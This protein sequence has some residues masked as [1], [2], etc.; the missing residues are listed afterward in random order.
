M[1]DIRVRFAPSPTGYLHVGGLRTAL[2]N[3]LFAK[4]NNGKIILRIEDTDQSRI[5]KGAT[6]GLIDIF[7]KF[8][9]NFDEGPNSKNNG[10]SYFQSN[11]LDI[12]NEHAKYL[13]EKGYAYKCH[14]SKQELVNLREEASDLKKDTQFL[15]EQIRSFSKKN[16]SESNYVIRFKTPSDQ[17]VE[18]NDIVR[19]VVKFNSNEIDDQILIKADGFPTYHM[20]NVVDDFN[21]KISHVI[22]GEEWLSSTPKHI[23]LY[24]AFGY[25]IP[26]FAH[27]PL[28]LNKDKSKLSKRQGDVSVED[29]LQKGYTPE[30]LINFVSLLGWHPENNEE[31]LS[32][33]KLID[34]FSINRVQKGGATFDIEKLNWINSNYIKNMPMDDFIS[35]AMK[36]LPDDLKS[37]N[38]KNKSFLIFMKDRVKTFNDLIDEAKWFYYLPKYIDDDIKILHLDINQQMLSYLRKEIVIVDNISEGFI[39][40]LMKKIETKFNIKG[41][42]LFFP[43]RLSI[44]GKTH[45]PNI[46]DIC[47]ILGKKQVLIRL[48][49]V[50]IKQC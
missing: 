13:L 20:A 48:N 10:S 8:D 32:L 38:T 28:L 39:L 12:Y 31:I 42:D 19:G 2:Y 47:N 1:K 35:T 30:A 34:I 15:R 17:L 23:L 21:M 36:F 46:Y 41:K 44:Y 24:K 27:L 4:Q 33:N 22:R 40:E 49:N 14:L 7:K 6:D 9:I 5:V 45:G 16:N 3:F 29:F 18:F 37:E 25:D 11:R 26:R 43:I 50:L